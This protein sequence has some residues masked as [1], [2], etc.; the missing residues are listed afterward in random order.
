MDM[1]NKAYLNGLRYLKKWGKI[2]YSRNLKCLEVL[3]F[4]FECNPTQKLIII[5]GFITNEEYAKAELDWY[6]AATNLIDYSPTIQKAWEKYSDD[7]KTVN[8]AYGYK[9]FSKSPLT[10]NISQWD[11]V[12]DKLLKDRDTRQAIINLNL[13]D[14]K[15]K[16]T[17]DFTCTMFLQFYIRGNKLHMFVILRSQDIYLGTR[18]DFYCFMSLQQKMAEELGIEVGAYRHYCV[19]LHIYERHFYK[20]DYID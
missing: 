6:L 18:N 5:P 17:K 9:I 3:N 15:L 12:K 4:E 14:D 2:V 16:P 13:I 7:G 19:S 11:W 20:L 10:H 8:S 1:T